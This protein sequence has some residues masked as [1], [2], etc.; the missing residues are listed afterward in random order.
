[1]RY[2]TA[3][4]DMDG[5]ILE[6]LEDMCASV[7]VTMDHVGYPRRTMDEV[8]RFVGNGAAKLI[9]R[10]M[11]A[12]AEDPRYPAALEFYRAYYDAHAQIK[13]GPYPGIPELLNQLSRE[14]V[15]LA[16]VSNKPDE[17]VR[18]LTERYFP[19]VFPVAIGNRD[20]WATKPAPDSVYEAMCLLGARREST[21]YVGDSDVDVDTARNAGL[22]SV[23]VTWGFRDEDFLRAHG[24]QHLAHNTDELYEML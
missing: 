24:A 22:D 9:E 12:G 16:V 2:Q 23:I 11:P 19:G 15:R 18:A 17:A 6:T 1:M 21:V 3:I 5:T 7:N 8:R 10:C 14:G 4:F 20:G 13:T